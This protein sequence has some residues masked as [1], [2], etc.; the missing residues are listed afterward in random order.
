VYPGINIAAYQST[1]VDPTDVDISS[2]SSDRLTF[3][4]I[5]RFER[6][7]NVALAVNA[8][9]LFRKA[10]LKP[11]Q[12]RLVLAG[13]YDP[14]VQ[15]N[16]ETLEYLVELATQSN[17]SYRL[18]S[19]SS[20]TLSSFQDSQKE[21]VDVLFLLNFTTA[22][23]TYLLTSPT[24]RALLYTPTNEHFGIGPVEGM[25]T[26]LPV[27]ATDTGGPTETVISSPPSL[28]TG[29]LEDS[30]P[31]TWCRA[32]EEIVGLT[33]QERLG[34][35]KRA[36]ERAGRLFSMEA[37]AKGMEN[38]LVEANEMGSL[39][40]EDGVI[41]YGLM[42]LIFLLSCWFSYTFAP[43]VAPPILIPT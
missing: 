23:R 25:I 35:S 3:L 27:L 11:S 4:S 40:R 33:E 41:G 18:L 14:R 13:G 39:R 10:I 9:T 6:K 36:K 7:K 16:K 31:E 2:I 34:L 29:W 8:F 17:L 12:Y 32:L 28:R 19:A 43:M 20:S 21:N 37:L 15:D 38:A 42:F 24:T 30:V 1:S 26:G 22:Q 5:N